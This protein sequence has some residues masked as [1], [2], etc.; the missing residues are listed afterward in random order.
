MRSQ[1]FPFLMAFVGFWAL[2]LGMSA[3]S[4]A[5][6]TDNASGN[7]EQTPVPL[8]QPILIDENNIP[9]RDWRSRRGYS[10]GTI[11]EKTRLHVMYFLFDNGV[12]S[13][14]YNDPAMNIFFRVDTTGWPDA[15][16]AYNGMEFVDKNGDG[17]NDLVI[18]VD[19]DRTLVWHWNPKDMNFDAVGQ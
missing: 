9:G 19:Q 5:Q 16:G 15:R 10:Y 18:K 17:Y 14:Y 8:V 3:V 4:H 2:V 7:A 13:F 11:D 6:S 12:I 1:H